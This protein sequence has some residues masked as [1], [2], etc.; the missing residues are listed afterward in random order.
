MSELEELISKGWELGDLYKVGS[1]T[2]A[3]WPW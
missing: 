1:P 2:L 3:G